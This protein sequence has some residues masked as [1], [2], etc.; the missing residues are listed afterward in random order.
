MNANLPTDFQHWPTSRSQPERT[1]RP[2]RL[3]PEG[4]LFV[5]I[6]T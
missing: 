3:H 6:S 4:I 1:P 5:G 2:S